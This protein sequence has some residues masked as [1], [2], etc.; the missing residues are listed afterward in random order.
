MAELYSR[1]QSPIAGPVSKT[2]RLGRSTGRADRPRQYLSGWIASS[3]NEWTCFFS[4]HGRRAGSAAVLVQG[5]RPGFSCRVVDE[6]T[7]AFPCYDGNGMFPV[8]GQPPAQCA[9]RHAVHRLREPVAPA[10]ST[11]SARSICRNPLLAGVSRKRSSSFPRARQRSFLGTVRD[12][13]TNFTSSSGRVSCHAT[14]AQR[15]SPTGSA[16]TGQ[17]TCLPARDPA[18]EG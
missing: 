13:S 3:S 10:G 15:L 16:P 9:C 4:G 8:D 11:A 2:R 18:R 5:R 6:H 12:T 17:T 14:T 1:G 7:L